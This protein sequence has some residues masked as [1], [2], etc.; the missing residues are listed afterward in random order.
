MMA[1]LN[2]PKEVAKALMRLRS[3]ADLKLPN[4][5]DLPEDQVRLPIKS[6]GTN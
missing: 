6:E 4:F 2:Y 5:P 3:V 1:N